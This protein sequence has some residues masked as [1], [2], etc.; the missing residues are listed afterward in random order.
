M[1]DRHTKQYRMIVYTC[2]TMYTPIYSLK[3]ITQFPHELILHTCH[4]GS[5]QGYYIDDEKNNENKLS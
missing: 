1:S 2:I 4:M 5:R 3:R